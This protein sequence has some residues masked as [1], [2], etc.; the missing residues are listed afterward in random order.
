M[1]TF[2]KPFRFAWKDLND[3]LNRIVDAIN[4][5]APLEGTGI[6]L[7]EKGGYGVSINRRDDK[8]GHPGDTQQQQGGGV[9]VTIQAFDADN[10][11]VMLTVMTDGS[12]F[13]TS[14]LAWQPITM[15]DP[16]T[17]AQSTKPL[18]GQASP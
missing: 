16:G 17:C 12:G 1:A 14:T 8:S 11:P 6:T 2:L 3:A 13:S 15:V 7:D 9:P 18:L 5:N 10:N 4:C